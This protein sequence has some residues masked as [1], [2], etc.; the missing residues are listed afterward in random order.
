MKNYI[1]ANITYLIKKSNCTQDEFGALFDLG[2]GIVNQY[3]REKSQPKIETVQKICKHY[4]ITIDEFINLD[5]SE[6][7]YLIHSEQREAAEPTLPTYLN[8]KYVKS[9]EDMIELQKEL[10]ENKNEII[11]SL[12]VNQG[13]AS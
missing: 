5:L 3:L 4:S 6:P 10:I 11:N 8:E 7:K 13:K 2:R 12:K 9:L 1:A